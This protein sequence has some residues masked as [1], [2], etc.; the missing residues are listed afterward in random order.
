M[1]SDFIASLAK[2]IMPLIFCTNFSTIFKKFNK[3]CIILFNIININLVILVLIIQFS[4]SCGRQTLSENFDFNPTTVNQDQLSSVRF[5]YS[6]H[7]DK[8]SAQVFIFTESNQFKN[9]FDLDYSKLNMLYYTFKT[10]LTDSVYSLDTS[11]EF[12]LSLKIDYSTCKPILR[13]QGQTYEFNKSQI[14]NPKDRILNDTTM[15]KSTNHKFYQQ[16]LH[17]KN[18]NISK[19]FNKTFKFKHKFIEYFDVLLSNNKLNYNLATDQ[20]YSHINF[21]IDLAAYVKKYFKHSNPFLAPS[22]YCYYAKD[23]MLRSGKYI[24]KSLDNEN[25]FSS[26]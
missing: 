3:N 17:I 6:I 7:L 23:T 15:Y 26:S 18:E 22:Q 19:E 13:T 4:V 21:A 2:N 1:T 20:S 9:P 25:I 14:V 16:D 12:L 11:Y 8:K 5:L 24:C 10:C